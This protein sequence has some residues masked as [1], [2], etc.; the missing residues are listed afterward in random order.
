M[1]LSAGIMIGRGWCYR[2]GWFCLSSRLTNLNISRAPGIILGPGSSTLFIE[3]VTEEDEGVY[4]CRATNQKGSAESSAYL[5]VQGKQRLESTR[6]RSDTYF[7][8]CLTS[9]RAV[10][11]LLASLASLSPPAPS[12]PGPR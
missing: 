12:R 4:H 9:R 8:V 2:S 5:T 1:S 10:P 7:P 11:R 3:R 6:N